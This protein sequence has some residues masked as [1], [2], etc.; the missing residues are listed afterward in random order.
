MMR[1]LLM[2][3]PILAAFALPLEDD[4][5]FDAEW[6]EWKLKHGKFYK[7]HK[8]EN[9]RRF[10]WGIN[11]QNIIKSNSEGKHSHKL[12]L[13]HFSDLVSKVNVFPNT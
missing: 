10:I 5:H 4:S 7:D 11:M 8:E 9:I 1:V 13:N 6:I 12:S 2:F 3:L